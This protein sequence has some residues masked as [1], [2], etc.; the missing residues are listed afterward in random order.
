M[1]VQVLQAKTTFKPEDRA[2]TMHTQ[3]RNL[4]NKR[5]SGCGEVLAQ[6]GWERP[7]NQEPW[8]ASQGVANFPVSNG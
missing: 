7:D 8:L 6:R 2:P 4:C 1:R 3:S 5:E